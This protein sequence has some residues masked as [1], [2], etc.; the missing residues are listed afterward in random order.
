MVVRKRPERDCERRRQKKRTL[1]TRTI[2]GIIEPVRLVKV[3]RAG[4]IKSQNGRRLRPSAQWESGAF[5][6]DQHWCPV[7]KRA[8]TKAADEAD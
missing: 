1:F 4:D 7:A 3:R 8:K 6:V 2:D 5:G